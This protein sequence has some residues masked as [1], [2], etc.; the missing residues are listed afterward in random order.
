MA[1]VW[2]FFLFIF[3]DVLLPVAVLNPRK[4]LKIIQHATEID[5]RQRERKRQDDSQA[6]EK[7]LD[8]LPLAGLDSICRVALNLDANL[9]TCWAN[10][11]VSS[12]Q[13]R[14][15]LQGGEGKLKGGRIEGGVGLED[16][17]PDP[18]RA[19]YQITN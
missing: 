6:K 16:Q 12:S 10:E 15:G 11:I 5:M 13:T 18:G 17:E 8:R 3:F 7:G 1:C 2:V 19:G 9:G 14:L 4:A